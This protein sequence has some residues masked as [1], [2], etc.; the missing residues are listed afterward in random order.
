[1][2]VSPFARPIALAALL[3]LAACTGTRPAVRDATPPHRP[4]QQPAPEITERHYRVYTGD[5]RP[6]T[7]DDVVAAM[8]DRAVVFVGETHDDPVAHVLELKLLEAAHVHHGEAR[9]VALSMEMF[10]RDVQYIVDEYLD[11][12]ITEHHFLT[13]VHPWS[14]YETDYRPLVEYARA[15]GLPVVAANAPRRYVNR[16]SRLGPGSLE[17]LSARAK[18]TLPPLPYPEPTPAY[19]ARW[20]RMMIQSMGMHG[21]AGDD[22]VPDADTVAARSGHGAH[23][24]AHVEISNMLYAQALW[25]ASMAHALAEFLQAH[26]EALILHTVGSFH[27]EGGTGAPEALQHYRPGTSTLNIAVRPA[28][29]VTSF[30]EEH[31]GAG[32][33]VILTDA[34]LPRTYK[35]VF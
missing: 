26:P 18:E 28:P 23:P 1:M 2:R 24:A 10:S 12:L 35:A 32:D 21:R 34:A 22:A 27:V 19:Q 6:A 5:G 29:D 20:N 3:L 4:Q 9:P 31:T 7:F 33:F 8:A 13:S 25:D 17:A 11:S 14:N 30:P 15:H 16:V